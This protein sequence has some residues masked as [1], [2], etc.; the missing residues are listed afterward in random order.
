MP[1]MRTSEIIMSSR[2]LLKAANARS[3]E[4][5]TTVSKPWLLRNESSKLRWPGSSSTIRIRGIRPRF[6]CVSFGMHLQPGQPGRVP[7]LTKTPQGSVHHNVRSEVGVG[8]HWAV[9]ANG[10]PA[11]PG[12]SRVHV[13]RKGTPARTD[14]GM[15]FGKRFAYWFRT[16]RSFLGTR[17]ERP[18]QRAYCS[19]TWFI[20]PINQARTRGAD[21]GITRQAVALLCHRLAATNTNA[22]F[23]RNKLAVVGFAPSGK[24]VRGTATL[25]PEQNLVPKTATSCRNVKVC[26]S[27]RLYYISIKTWARQIARWSE[28]M[29]PRRC[30]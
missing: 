26:I 18:F 15:P 8:T 22:R 19:N 13:R 4:T 7:K 2:S 1:G 9:P 25:A 12:S 6:V 29:L 24:W 16:G 21:V 20:H 11:V 23:H 27:P 5:T 14:S 3:P 28:T 10:A 17:W 30:S